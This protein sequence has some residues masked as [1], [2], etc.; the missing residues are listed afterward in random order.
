MVYLTVF[1]VCRIK[2]HNMTDLI[3][4][5]FVRVKVCES[6]SCRIICV[7][8]VECGT[9]MTHTIL[10]LIHYNTNSIICHVLIFSNQGYCT[11]TDKCNISAGGDQ[12]LLNL[13]FSD[14]ATKDISRH[15]PFLY[16]MVSTATYSYLP[17]YK[18]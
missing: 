15:L 16:N 11:Q 5:I 10:E 9:K 14:W 13:Y 3:W 8:S 18:A 6:S 17:A 2:K 1:S 7:V 4:R 12:G